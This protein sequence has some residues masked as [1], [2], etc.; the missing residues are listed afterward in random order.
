MSDKGSTPK[1]AYP[2]D[3]TRTSLP[4]DGGEPLFSVVVKSVVGTVYTGGQFPPRVAAFILIAES[5]ITGAFEFPTEDGRIECVTV[6][7]RAA[8][9]IPE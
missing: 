1:T 2:F 3:T 7:Q 5:G 6:D 8:E 4:A 9:E